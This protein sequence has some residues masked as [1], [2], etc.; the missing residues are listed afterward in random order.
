[1]PVMYR[2]DFGQLLGYSLA[3]QGVC[4]AKSGEEGTENRLTKRAEKS[5]LSICLLRIVL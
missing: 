3:R 4:R 2:K 1:M 5:A